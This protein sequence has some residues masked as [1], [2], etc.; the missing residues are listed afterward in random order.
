[1]FFES[2]TFPFRF[3]LEACVHFDFWSIFFSLKGSPLWFEV[4]FK[5]FIFLKKN[6]KW[7]IIGETL[8][9][10]QKKKFFIPKI[11]M[12]TCFQHKSEGKSAW[13]ENIVT[14]L[15]YFCSY[16]SNHRSFCLVLIVILTISLKNRRFVQILFGFFYFIT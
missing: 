3:M 12:Y 10:I 7:K 6:E 5:F 14:V 1:M 15:F 2:D 9:K 8:W 11:K 16:P 4:F 13:L